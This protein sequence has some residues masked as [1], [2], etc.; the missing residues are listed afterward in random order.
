MHHTKIIT[1][2]TGSPLLYVQ[3]VLTRTKGARLGLQRGGSN[4]LNFANIIFVLNTIISFPSMF[5]WV[6]CAYPIP[7]YL[8][9]NSMSNALLITNIKICFLKQISYIIKFYF[10]EE[11][12]RKRKGTLPIYK[13]TCTSKSKCD[14][15][16]NH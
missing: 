13:T 7:K 14:D 3:E 5:K 10:R 15:S 11:N 1:K 12:Q 2:S 6:Y 16:G 8:F 9:S 4:T